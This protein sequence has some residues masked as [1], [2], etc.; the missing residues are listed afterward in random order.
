MKAVLAEVLTIGDEILYGQIT[1]TN[2]QFISAELSKIGVRTIRHTSIGDTAA[3]ISEALADALQRVDVVIC[4]GGL[5]PT[6]DDITKKTFADFFGVQMH[7][8]EAIWLHIQELFGKRNRTPNELNR[9]QALVPDNAQVIHN[10]VGTA[11]GLWFEDKGKVVISMPGVPFETQKMFAEIAIP[12][13]KAFFNPPVIFHKIIRTINCP[14]S[15]LAQLIEKWEDNLPEHIKLAYLP[16]FGQVRLRLTAFGTDQAQ[17]EAQVAQEIEKV[18]PIIQEFVFGFDNDEL[19]AAIADILVK[20]NKSLATAESCTGGFLAHQFT[21]MAGSSAYFMGGIV[22]YSNQIK[23]EQLGVKAE[24]IDQ[25]GAVSEQTVSQMAQNVRQ[26][27]KT[28][29]G[30]ATTGIAGP[31]GGSAEKPVGTVWIACSTE[32]GVFT[33]KLQLTTDRTTNIQLTSSQI[34]DFTR[35]ILLDLVS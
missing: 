31:A 1:N 6:K 33:K 14:E 35:K 5:G 2:S 15:T 32:K 20:Q 17:L 21:K 4:T 27:Y 18:M 19:E 7:Y 10:A 11:P 30:I 3:Q 26:L 23:I 12:K 24:T 29:V 16:K 34:L 9:M 25:F 8:E 13:I 22:A 28:D